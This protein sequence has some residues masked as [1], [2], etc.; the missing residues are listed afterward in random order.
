MRRAVTKEPAKM[1][2]RSKMTV[3]FHHVGSKA[4]ALHVTAGNASEGWLIGG[5]P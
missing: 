3:P 2:R 1:A 5:E 4:R